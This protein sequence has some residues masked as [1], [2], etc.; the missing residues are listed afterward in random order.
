MLARTPRD[1]SLPNLQSSSY[2]SFFHLC[3]QLKALLPRKWRT[4][5]QQSMLLSVLSESQP[6]SSYC[7]VFLAPFL[8]PSSPLVAAFLDKSNCCKT[9]CCACCSLS[10]KHRKNCECCPVSLLIVRKQ[11]LSEIQ[12]LNCQNSNQCLNCQKSL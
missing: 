9:C 3:F 12:V 1:P 10:Y 4:K 5:T 7:G 11:R 8:A 6:M 2:R